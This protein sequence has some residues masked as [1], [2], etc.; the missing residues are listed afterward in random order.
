[1]WCTDDDRMYLFIEQCRYNTF[2]IR[3]FQGAV[4]HK[5][6][7]DIRFADVCIIKSATVNRSGRLRT[8]GLVAT[9]FVSGN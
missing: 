3:F 8:C 4:F 2:I 5:L 9:C 6:S 7:Y 1:M